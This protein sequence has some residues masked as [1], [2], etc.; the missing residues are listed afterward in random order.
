MQ[1]RCRGRLLLRNAA[2]LLLL[3]L[4]A[5]PGGEAPG[6]ARRQLIMGGEED[7]GPH[8]FVVSLQHRNRHF[9]GGTLLDEWHVLTAAHC[10]QAVRC[11]G[12]LCEGLDVNVFRRNVSMLAEEEYP[13][14]SVV[15]RGAAWVSNPLYSGS[16]AHLHDIAIIRLRDRV[17][18]ISL[19]S[20]Y[21]LSRNSVAR[22]D[23][24][25]QPLRQS[26]VRSGSA[27]Q[28]VGWGRVWPDG[29]Q[30]SDLLDTPMRAILTAECRRAWPATLGSQQICAA[31]GSDGEVR[32]VCNGDSGGPLLMPGTNVQVGIVSY[33]H[34]CGTPGVPS[35]FTD[36]R[37]VEHMAFI[38]STIICLDNP[39]CC[40]YQAA[41]DGVVAS[42]E[43]CDDGNNIA[44][45]GCFC[46]HLEDDYFCH[47]SPSQCTLCVDVPLAPPPRLPRGMRVCA[48]ADVGCSGWAQRGECQTNPGYMSVRCPASC[49]APGCWVDTRPRPQPA[50]LTIQVDGV[51]QTDV[52]WSWQLIQRFSNGHPDPVVRNQGMGSGFLICQLPEDLDYPGTV[53]VYELHINSDRWNTSLG[54]DISTGGQ[55]TV[56][57]PAWTGA[58]TS[59]AFNLQ[60]TAAGGFYGAGVADSCVNIQFHD[61]SGSPPSIVANSPAV[62]GH[63]EFQLG[64]TEFIMGQ[65]AKACGDRLD[66]SA[67]VRGKIVVLDRGDCYFVHKAVIAQQAGAIGLLIVNYDDDANR[68]LTANMGAASD[69]SRPSDNPCCV[70]IPLAMITAESGQLLRQTPQMQ[71][72]MRA[73]ECYSAPN[74]CPAA[75]IGLIKPGCGAC[76]R[77]ETLDCNEVCR[78]AD[79]LGNG[80]CDIGQ[81]ISGS[82][83]FSCSEHQYDQGDCPAVNCEDDP[84]WRD[85]LGRACS[86][87]QYQAVP[88]V[89]G[90]F[91]ESLVQC[92]KSCHTCEG[93]CNALWSTVADQGVATSCAKVSF[94]Y[95]VSC[96]DVEAAGISC[97]HARFCGY[98]GREQE[99]CA[100]GWQR[101][102]DGVCSPIAWVGDGEC[103]SGYSFN[104]AF[105]LNCKSSGWWDGGDCVSAQAISTTT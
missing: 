42:S 90:E 70:D 22:V 44:G 63:S 104:T 91:E 49:A 33:S 5:L 64:L 51:L 35:V 105:N 7:L 98:C 100:R 55:M 32:D 97:S 39:R 87:A 74:H 19:C 101:D 81:E 60:G 102:C 96:D 36:P 34:K 62:F 46:G 9:C 31:G 80:E 67:E 89:C 45:D 54:F 78:S 93:A 79:L 85:P 66:N 83:D 13:G 20:R 103:D 99:E 24:L 23:L 16:P 26:G 30:G 3:G 52:D 6:T 65:P 75:W 50:Y 53:P 95:G 28:A 47:G 2:G 11:T 43:E 92:Q 27:V 41:S 57:V 59:V 10:E 40:P 84:V 18:D 17:P 14:C 8:A 71:I 68:G 38:Q 72:S 25:E 86:D 1:Y 77:G 4:A 94:V 12:E 61:G 76:G 29:P 21:G 37:T 69:A 82:A 56:Q 48:D 15:L 73:A 58:T 88:G